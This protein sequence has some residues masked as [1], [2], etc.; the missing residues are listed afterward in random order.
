MEKDPPASAKLADNPAME[1]PV[2]DMGVL[3]PLSASPTSEICPAREPVHSSHNKA[4]SAVTPPF[5]RGA[6]ASVARVDPIHFYVDCLLSEFKRPLPITSGRLVP[7]DIINTAANI[8][9]GACVFELVPFRPF[10]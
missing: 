6:N 9:E 1:E 3:L 4:A 7:N 5:G 8:S 10:G 2:D